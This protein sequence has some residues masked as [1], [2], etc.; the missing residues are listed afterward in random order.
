MRFRVNQPKVLNEL[1]DGEV[2]I[3]NLETGNYYSL[4]HSAA[5]IW[6]S[7][8][9]AATVGDIVSALAA[10]YHG[11]PEV[12]EGEVNRFLRELQEEGLI[13]PSGDG[14]AGLADGSPSPGETQSH[15]ERSAF[16][17][18]VLEKFDDM[19]SLILLD[20][21]HEVNV[22]EGWPHPKPEGSR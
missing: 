21:V 22:E 10:R 12:F 19:Q 3:I 7:I 18:P 1:I 9:R 14:A 20:P 11:A 6:S 13:V 5:I 8:G 15:I 2:V 17:P 4:L 16:Q